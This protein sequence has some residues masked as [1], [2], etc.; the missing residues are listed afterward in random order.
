M[1]TQGLPVLYPEI[2]VDNFHVV[3]VEMT[4]RLLGPFD[5]RLQRYQAG[6]GAPGWDGA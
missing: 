1:K 6:P 4:D 5:R 2:G 3:L